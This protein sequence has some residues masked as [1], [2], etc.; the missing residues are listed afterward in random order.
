MRGGAFDQRESQQVFKYRGAP[1][2]KPLAE[3]DD[4]LVF[5][6]PPLEAALVVTGA[7]VAELFVSSDCPDTDFTVKLID[8]YPANADYPDGFAMNITDGIFRLRYRDGWE[9]ETMAEP[10]VTYRIE[11]R[12]FAV[13]NRFE[14]G[15]RLRLDVS[16]SNFPHFDMNPNTGAPEGCADA[17]RVATNHVHFG[18]RYPSRIV[19]PVVSDQ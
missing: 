2:G 13:S 17:F 3:R 9:S 11:I 8:V 5:Q 7:I 16:S 1:S 19:L 12:P 6:T 10:G 14:A 4:V 18:M 15:H